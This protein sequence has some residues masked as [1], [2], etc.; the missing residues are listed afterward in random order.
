[1]V[2]FSAAVCGEERFVTT[3]K[4]ALRQTMRPT[5]NEKTKQMQSKKKKLSVTYLNIQP[6]GYR[7]TNLYMMCSFFCCEK[8]AKK[9]PICQ[10]R[11]IVHSSLKVLNRSDCNIYANNQHSGRP[12]ITRLLL[13]NIHMEPDQKI[14]KDD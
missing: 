10:L 7:C 1:M 12:V 9:N 2:R 14:R 3:L 6:Q 5:K 11:N 8:T 4:P 13:L